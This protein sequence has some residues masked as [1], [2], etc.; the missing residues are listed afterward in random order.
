[1]R[2]LAQRHDISYLS[3]AEPAETAGNLEGMREVASHVV[4][5][6]RSDAG[7]GT[8]T[9]YFDA[10]RYLVDPAPYAVAKYR[11]AAYGSQ[12]LALPSAGSTRWSATSCHRS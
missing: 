12:S 1:M 9:F 7:K 4:T 11:S 8:A 2:H 6:P 3:F 5:V 10:A